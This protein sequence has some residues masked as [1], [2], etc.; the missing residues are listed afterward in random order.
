MA[1]SAAQL[2]QFDVDLPISV[3]HARRDDLLGLEWNSEMWRFRDLF[4][5]AFDEA[6]Q[7]RRMMLIAD[8][9]GYPVGRIFAQL[10]AGNFYYADGLSRAYLYSLAVMPML[11]GHGIGTQLVLAAESELAARGYITVTIAVAVENERAKQLYERLGYQVFR[12]DNSKWAYQDPNGETHHINEMCWAL[13][14]EL[15][16]EY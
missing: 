5:Q 14:K 10:C 16:E 7:E 12:K 8:A 4:R 9:G 13:K 15:G 3:R 2:A 1:Q 11:Q 6:Q